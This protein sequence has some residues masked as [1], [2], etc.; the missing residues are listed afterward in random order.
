LFSFGLVFILFYFAFYFH[1]KMRTESETLASLPKQTILGPPSRFPPSSPSICFPSPVSQVF[2]FASGERRSADSRPD[3]STGPISH[4]SGAEMGILYVSQFYQLCRFPGSGT[5]V[6]KEMKRMKKNEKS[7]K[8]I[9]GNQHMGRIPTIRQVGNPESE[10]STTEANHT[11]LKKNK[12][13]GKQKNPRVV[14][15]GTEAA[16]RWKLERGNAQFCFGFPGGT[17][18][19]LLNRCI[20]VSV[21]TL[22]GTRRA[23]TPDPSNCVSSAPLAKRVPG[24]KSKSPACKPYS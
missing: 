5:Q 20:Y 2:T 13:Q 7:Q 9:S 12:G 8:G 16:N 3:R 22:Q 11:V 17:R 14:A 15:L 6:Q 21:R 1:F 19:T 23:Q 4:G 24:Q 10:G 18:R